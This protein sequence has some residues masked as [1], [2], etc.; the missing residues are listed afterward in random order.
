MR[1]WLVLCVIGLAAVA[2]IEGQRA[3][4]SAP[5][6]GPTMTIETVKGTVEIRFFPDDAPK[7]V[8]H[9]LALAKRNFYRGQRVHRVERTLVQFGDPTSRDMSRRDWWGR[10]GSGKPVG[11]SELNKRLHVRGAVAL[12]HSGNASYADS[13]MYIMKVAS[14]SLDGKHVVIGQVTRGMDVVDKLEVTDLFKQVTIA[15]P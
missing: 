1:Q 6:P 11:V 3:A 2:T 4:G 10:S 5:P 8:A 15:E 13:Q 12:A 9:I 14:P 7:S